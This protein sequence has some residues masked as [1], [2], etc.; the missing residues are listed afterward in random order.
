MTIEQIENL[1]ES[2]TEITSEYGRTSSVGVRVMYRLA[3]KRY[4]TVCRDSAQNNIIVEWRI[5]KI[6]PT[7][8]NVSTW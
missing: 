8:W 6:R 5:T 4:L 1:I 3:D 7:K 2:A